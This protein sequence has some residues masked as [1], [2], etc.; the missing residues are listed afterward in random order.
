M[1]MQVLG[2]MYKM[3]ITVHM[4]DIKMLNPTTPT[5][6]CVIIIVNQGATMLGLVSSAVP[7]PQL[8]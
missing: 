8:M 4:V 5:L 7:T 1:I 3:D 6:Q 2:F